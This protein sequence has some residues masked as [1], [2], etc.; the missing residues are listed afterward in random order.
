MVKELM[1]FDRTS[2]DFLNGLDSF[3][4]FALR[5]APND[6]YCPY[7]RCDNVQRINV[8]EVKDH[9]ICN[10]IDKSYLEALLYTLMNG[11]SARNKS[12]LVL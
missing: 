4:K 11:S 7:L 2:N 9:V 8:S 5:N 12:N 10:T 6:I 1:S 3:L